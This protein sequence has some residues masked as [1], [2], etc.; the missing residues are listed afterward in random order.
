[1][2]ETLVPWL[3]W[4]TLMN[5]LDKNILKEF[6]YVLKDESDGDVIEE[7]S[8]A[9]QLEDAFVSKLKEKGFKTRGISKPTVITKWFGR[10]E[11]KS[12]G[13]SKSFE[14]QANRLVSFLKNDKNWTVYRTNKY[15]PFKNLWNRIRGGFYISGSLDKWNPADILLV[16]PTAAAELRKIK[17]ID[18]AN[19]FFY[20]CIKN[21]KHI[22]PV[23]LKKPLVGKK[24]SNITIPN[25]KRVEGRPDYVSNNQGFKFIFPGINKFSGQI[26]IFSGGKEK[27]ITVRIPRVTNKSK[28]SKLRDLVVFE[29][30]KIKDPVTGNYFSSGQH[31]KISSNF[32]KLI[33]DP[34]NNISIPDLLRK[35]FFDEGEGGEIILNSDGENALKEINKYYSSIKKLPAIVKISSPSYYTDMFSNKESFT[36]KAADLMPAKEPSINYLNGRLSSLFQTIYIYYYFSKAYNDNKSAVEKSIYNMSQIAQSK[37]EQSSPHIK[38][39]GKKLLVPK[40]VLFS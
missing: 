18:E 37:S 13:I 21:K 22:I 3:T 20:D 11:K 24:R 26:N 17:T 16:K 33:E 12:P 10:E 39:E 1:M 4:G 25:F 29:M 23:S 7:A 5:E 28:G 19:N 40:N 32:I 38:L 9:K 34:N 2:L 6:L 27:N 14:Q 15:K 30:S 36:K 31:G 8:T 35:D